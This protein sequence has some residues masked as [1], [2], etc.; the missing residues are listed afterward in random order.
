MAFWLF[1][2]AAHN[3]DTVYVV[4]IRFQEDS[5]A[6]ECWPDQVEQ[7]TAGSNSNIWV[8]SVQP[9]S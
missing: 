4:H 5:A 8:S 2:G 1:D 7:S 6:R 3:V 9:K